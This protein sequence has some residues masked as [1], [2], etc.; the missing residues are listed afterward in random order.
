M[1]V[2]LFDWNQYEVTGGLEEGDEVAVFMVSRALQ[3]SKEFADRIRGRSM[4]GFKKTN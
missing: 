1:K 2:G 4:P 3:Q